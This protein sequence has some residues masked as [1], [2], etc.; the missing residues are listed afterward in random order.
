ML[1][2][3]LSRIDVAAVPD[4][5]LVHT[6]GDSRERL[7]PEVP[8]MAGT[9]EGVPACVGW[10]ARRFERRG[11]LHRHRH[12]EGQLFLLDEGTCEVRCGSE[13]WL[14]RPGQPCWVPPHLPHEVDA[15]GLVT[16]WTVL[17]AEDL[18]GAISVGPALIHRAD[19]L[20]PLV[21]RMT[22]GDLGDVRAERLLAVLLDELAAGIVAGPV[23][24]M[25]SHD[26]LRSF[27]RLIAEAPDDQRGLAECG[28]SVGMSPRTFSRRFADET[29][30]SF[31][32]WRCCARVIKA[33]ELI[34]QGTTVTQAS[35]QVG[36]D[37]QSAFSNTFR[38]W[39][40]RT[41]TEYRKGSGSPRDRVIG[42]ACHGRS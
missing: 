22:D 40:G 10:T 14:V 24:R 26:R 5:E 17:I 21:T 25:P 6:S 1:Q 36:Y 15:H 11:Y 34:R 9:V 41:P 12:P 19:L 8:P 7:Q 31:M 23:L 4:P 13:R 32:Q 33:A 39:M 3:S 16:G 2:E 29:G 37:S 28:R 42:G 35:L 20:I 18:C 38:H 27:A 30:L